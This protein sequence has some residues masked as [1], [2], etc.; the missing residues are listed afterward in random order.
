MKR[1]RRKIKGNERKRSKRD[2][3]TEGIKKR[4]NER[5]WKGI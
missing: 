5:K 3:E 4:E 2:N 1:T